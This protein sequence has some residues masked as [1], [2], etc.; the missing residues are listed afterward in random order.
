MN[1]PMKKQVLSKDECH[2]SGSYH[3]KSQVGDPIA[4]G[5]I[6]T[7]NDTEPGWTVTIEYF[8][9]TYLNKYTKVRE[10]TFTTYTIGEARAIAKYES[11]YFHEENS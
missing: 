7:M 5:Y 11:I 10:M 6:I 4:T 9:R 3:G 8:C 2:E 1:N